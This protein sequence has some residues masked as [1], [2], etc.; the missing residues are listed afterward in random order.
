[1]EPGIITEVDFVRA[2]DGDT[3]EVE[4]TRRFSIRLRNIDCPERNTPEGQEAKA[5]VQKLLEESDRILAFIPSNDPVKLM[6][7]NSFNRIIGDLVAYEVGFLPETEVN[8]AKHLKSKG[9]VK[10]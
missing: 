10:K 3:I 7:I 1:M 4:I 9:F 5:E 2:I 6:D 8:V